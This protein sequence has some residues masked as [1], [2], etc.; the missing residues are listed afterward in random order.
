[1]KNNLSLCQ[2]HA[3][4][5]SEILIDFYLNGKLKDTD[6]QLVAIPL[7]ISQISICLKDQFLPLV[8]LIFPKLLED[9]DKDVQMEID[10]EVSGALRAHSS[11]RASRAS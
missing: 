7:T 3:K 8:H 10:G 4:E 5:I 11:T 6:P 9:A 2:D 1:M